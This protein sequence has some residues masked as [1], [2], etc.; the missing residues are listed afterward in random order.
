MTEL[1]WTIVGWKVFLHINFWTQKCTPIRLW[2]S[3]LEAPRWALAPS[4]SCSCHHYDLRSSQAF[5]ILFHCLNLFQCRGVWQG[6]ATLWEQNITGI[7][8]TLWWQSMKGKWVEWRFLFGRVIQFSKTSNIVDLKLV[9]MLFLFKVGLDGALLRNAICICF[10]HVHMY[11]A[12]WFGKVRW[13]SRTSNIQ[14]SVW[15][16]YVES[17][18]RWF[19]SKLKYICCL[20]AFLLKARLPSDFMDLSTRHRVAAVQRK[21][22]AW[23]KHH[24][25]YL[26]H[27]RIWE[28]LETLIHVKSQITSNWGRN[29]CQSWTWWYINIETN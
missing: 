17:Y 28:F 13:S 21:M 8:G 7:A 16:L 1:W 14:S 18:T 22:Y 3:N 9:F 20:V 27:S 26:S 23:W 4:T 6:A 5:S 11:L 10:L 19:V 29:E 24:T 15:L 25:T 12:S 2:W